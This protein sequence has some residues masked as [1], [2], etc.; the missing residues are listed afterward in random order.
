AALFRSSLFTVRQGDQEIGIGPSA[1]LTGL[2][3]LV[4]R[5]VDRRRAL[6]RLGRDDLAGL[7]FDRDYVALTELCTGALQNL[8]RAD[9][10]ALGELAARLKNQ[11]DLSDLAKLDCFALQLLTLVGPK[12]VQAAAQR[13]LER[14]A[15][16]SPEP[17]EAAKTDTAVPPDQIQAWRARLA[18]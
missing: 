2:L 15:T 8:D 1:L 4:D 16:E 11:P 18:V 3:G 10:Q 5:S 7:S 17:D 13:L 6:E 12:A 9:A 14:R